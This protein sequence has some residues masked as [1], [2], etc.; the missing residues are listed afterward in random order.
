MIKALNNYK[1][2][3]RFGFILLVCIIC[4]ALV[5]A[6]FGAMHGFQNDKSLWAGVCVG[7]KLSGDNNGMK[8][9]VKCPGQDEFVTLNSTVII[10]FINEDRVFYCENFK[11]N[12]MK[13]EWWN[14]A[15]PGDENVE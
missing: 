6:Q 10:N 11:G 1:R 7:D 2:E 14:C 9:T 3:V 8:M 15:V 5:A 12:I 4:A 13:N